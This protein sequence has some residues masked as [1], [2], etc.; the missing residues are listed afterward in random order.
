MTSTKPVYGQLS[1][2]ITEWRNAK[3]PASSSY[4]TAPRVYIELSASSCSSTPQSTPALGAALP[5]TLTFPAS[6]PVPGST[7]TISLKQSLRFGA[8]RCLAA[9]TL[10]FPI[11]GP[12]GGL[13]EWHQLE[14]ESEDGSA[15]EGGEGPSVMVAFRWTS[16]VPPT[17]KREGPIKVTVPWYLTAEGL[18]SEGKG[19]WEKAL[20]TDRF[21]IG[22]AAKWVDVKV[23]QIIES[24]KVGDSDRSTLD[25]LIEGR[26]RDFDEGVVSI[27][28]KVWEKVPLKDKLNLDVPL[29]L[30]KEKRDLFGA[31]EPEETGGE[32]G[33]VEGEGERKT[34]RRSVSRR[35]FGGVAR[36]GG[37]AERD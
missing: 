4:L 29:N 30:T 9:K 5:L 36:G 31:K 7:L 24:K 23:G 19:A 1:A 28:P 34:P 8:D 27:A 35:L 2:T 10:E 18:Y 6:S 37:W 33:F 25:K 13:C 14:V 12:K 3:P 11:T 20:E 17:P 15:V 22:P 21:Y 32:G 16:K 26:L